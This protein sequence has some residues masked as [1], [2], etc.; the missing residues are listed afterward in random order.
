MMKTQKFGVEIELTGITREQVANIIAEYYGT[1]NTYE[2]GGYYTYTA[3]DKQDRVWRVMSDASIEPKKKTSNGRT[4]SAN[5]NYK[6]EIVTP[7]LK[8]DDIEDLQ[9]II[10]LVRK[11]GGF[12]TSNCGVHIHVDA[13]KHTP[14]TLKN[15]VNIIASKEDMLYK[16]LKIPFSRLRY[17]R[18]L[19][20]EV[21]TTINKKRPKTLAELA[22]AWYAEYPNEDRN[23]HYNSS[24]YHGLNLHS[25]FTKKTVEFRCFNS[26]LHAG[27]I[28]AYIQFCLAVNHQVLSQ[29]TAQYKR[30]FTNN[31]KYAFRCW[32]L[33][34]G[35]IG[36]EFKT[37]RLHFLK[38]LDGDAAWRNPNQRHNIA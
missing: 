9:E 27:E 4:I 20:E 34:L 14:Q 3:K 5:S 37:C 38:N 31:P 33:R 29:K 21:I 2:G 12:A 17:C 26:T 10:R 8:Y 19:N 16:T 24:R 35:L 32:M 7:I 18:K 25:T 11:N 36:E 13:S 1:S 15:L 28:K 22:D 30:T 6:V 23:K